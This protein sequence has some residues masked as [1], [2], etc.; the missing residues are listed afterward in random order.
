VDDGRLT[1]VD[2]YFEGY[3][4]PKKQVWTGIGPL[5][6]AFTQVGEVALVQNPPTTADP[7][8][9]GDGSRPG[10][11]GKAPEMTRS[12]QARRKSIGSV[13]T[14]RGQSPIPRTSDRSRTSDKARTPIRRQTPE[15]E[16][17]QDR[18]KSHAHPATPTF[19]PDCQ[20]LEPLPTPSSRT[21]SVRDLR[22]ASG[23][24]HSEHPA[25][26]EKQTDPESSQP[27]TLHRIPGRY[28]G[29]PEISGFG[30]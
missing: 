28:S 6:H 18:G 24:Q 2:G 22:T 20:M 14:G 9:Q 29:H 21:T 17:T 3:G 26:S 19:P 15:R 25:R 10:S 23:G 11:S 7:S 8:Q 4:L 16:A 5:N 12:S 27:P 30:S 1:R 13:R